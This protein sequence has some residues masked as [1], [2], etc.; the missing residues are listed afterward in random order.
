MYLGWICCDASSPGVR[1]RC[2][3]YESSLLFP[4]VKAVDVIII[5]SEIREICSLIELTVRYNSVL[6]PSLT[7]SGWFRLWGATPRGSF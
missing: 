7:S 3:D 6:P 5:Y 1:V 2:M 4:C